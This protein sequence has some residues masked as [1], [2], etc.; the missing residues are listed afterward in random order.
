MKLTEIVNQDAV[1]PAIHAQDREGAI[2]ELID[3][4]VKS[5]AAPE[6][7]REDLLRSILERERKSSTGFG[8]GVAVPHIKHPEVNTLCAA[9]G[10]SEHGI[11][12]A[13]RDE[14]PVYTVFLLL[15]PA[16]RPEEHLQ[17]MET[18]FK[19]LSKEAFRRFIR[20]AGSR[21]EI[22]KLLDDADHARLG[23]S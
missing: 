12:F 5:G 23:E 19:N 21:E 6:S 14:L 3:A 20:Q 15:S 17:A 22:L 11:D 10:L 18:I 9:V 7:I 13:A 2:A 1:V 4:L 16:S 8:Y